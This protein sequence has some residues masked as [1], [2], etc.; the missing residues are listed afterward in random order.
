MQDLDVIVVGG[1]IAG[2]TTA[3]ALRRAGHRVRVLEQTRE[4][5]PT[6]AGIS[7][8]SNGVKVLDALGLGAD[9]A[10]IGGAMERVCYRDRDGRLLCDFS[11]DPLVDRVGERAYPV[12]RSDLQD[13]LLRAAGGQVG[14]GRRG[15][16]IEDHPDRV[17]VCVE[18]GDRLEADVAVV[19]DGT[20]SRLRS[21]VLGAPVERTYVG[22]QNWNGIVDNAAALGAVD[23]W[24]M[25]VG[26]GKRVST[27]PVRDG[28]YFF[29]DVP[30][31]HATTTHD[32]PRTILRHHFDGW[33]DT[34]VALIEAIE[35]SGTAN[36]AIHTHDPISSFARG[37]VVLVGDSAHTTAPDLGQGGCL[38]ME[39][40]LVL[41]HHLTTTSIGVPDALARYSAERVPRTAQIMARA[42]K[43]AQLTH[44]HDPS[45]TAEWYR[46]LATEDGSNI[47]DGISESILS[48]PCR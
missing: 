3:A 7:L 38:A 41:A 9:I 47:I 15:V 14:T 36:I 2:L 1:G 30:T 21:A 10:A 33:S 5:R 37:R 19:A 18:G 34:V 45:R 27:M 31:P 6:G 44:A 11:L 8:W 24:T 26:D 13:L 35:P 22:Y 32:D 16:T 29:F 43:R 25:H 48:G 40:A 17:V 20:H 23:S 46:E 4:L 39:D 28:Q 12:R 42:L